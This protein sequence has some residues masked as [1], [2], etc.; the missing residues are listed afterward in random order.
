M[1]AVVLVLVE[2]LIVID[3]R[4]SWV[5]DAGGLSNR[6]DWKIIGIM[7]GPSLFGL[8]APD[9]AAAL[10]PAEAVPFLNVL[11]QVGLIFFMFLIGLELKYLSGQLEVAVLIPT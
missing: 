9:L 7:L 1:N 6:Y 11:S 3:C 2:V 5:W 4:G 10:F 8:V